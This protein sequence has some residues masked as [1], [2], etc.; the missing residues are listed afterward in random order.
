MPERQLSFEA[1]GTPWFIDA[2]GFADDNDWLTL[3]NAIR[4]RIDRFDKTYSRF[5]DDSLVTRMS[6]AAGT[7]ELDVDGYALLHFYEQLYEATGG[8]ITPLIGQTMAD[9]GYDAMYSLIP[10][11]LRQPPAWET[12]ISYDKDTLTLQQPALLDFGA[13]GKGYIVDV[14]HDLLIAAGSTGH[15]I[16]A[17]GDI[18]Q[19]ASVKTILDVGLENPQNTNEVI[20]IAH[21]YN[22]SICASSG[23]RRT[24]GDY[25]HIIN[26]HTLSSPTEVV[27]TWVVADS[28]M[29][30]DGL[31]TALF[32]TEPQILRQQFDFSYALLDNA[33]ALTRSKDFPATVYE[34]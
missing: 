21:I 20:G 24:W 7:Y 18:R 13:A 28:A 26:P 30:A 3:Q 33:M 14:I 11:Q 15:V 23:S 10:K 1:I 9:A 27:A 16:N 32:F 25:H 29:L 17:G 5:R 8:N 19:Y 2:Q 4:A 22:Q 6:Q 12:V 34:A 31:A